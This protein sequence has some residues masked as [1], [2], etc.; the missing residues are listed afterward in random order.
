MTQISRRSF[1]ASSSTLLAG[2]TVLVPAAG[3]LAASVQAS[4]AQSAGLQLLQLFR[5]PPADAAD[6]LK[7]IIAAMETAKP[8]TAWAVNQGGSIVVASKPVHGTAAV[9]TGIRS[10][11]SVRS[12]EQLAAL[13]EEQSE[14]S[15]D[16]S[17]LGSWSIQPK[18]AVKVLQGEGAGRWN[19]VVALVPGSKASGRVVTASRPAAGAWQLGS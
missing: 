9:R 2:A 12:G 17:A 10:V 11:Q 13:V 8:G 7:A 4:A 19:I 3:A 18:A 1:L 15:V 6:K 14:R 5:V 16:K